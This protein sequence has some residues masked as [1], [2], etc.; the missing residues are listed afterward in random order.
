[1]IPKIIHYV[2]FGGDNMLSQF[3]KDV[4]IPSI[5]KYCGDWEIKIWNESN[6]DLN[7]NEYVR[8][9]YKHKKYNFLSDYIRLYVLYKYGGIY[10]DTDVEIIKPLDDLLNNKGF[11][12][13]QKTLTHYW[14]YTNSSELHEA[15]GNYIPALGLIIG[16]ESNDKYIKEIL[17]KF[18]VYNPNEYILM[19]Y[20]K[21]LLIKD[22]FK[23]TDII[24]HINHWTIYPSEYFCPIA[25][26]SSILN[27]TD[28][29]YTIHHYG[30]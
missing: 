27:L 22:G 8:E 24:Q 18:K 11:C 30:K 7:M 19:D 21:E 20:T 29:T 9:A 23:Q 26:K 14:Y 5:Y 2:H 28:N 13:I 15:Y 1:M 6:I 16:V 12:G 3:R 10:V 25:F 17:E 4:C